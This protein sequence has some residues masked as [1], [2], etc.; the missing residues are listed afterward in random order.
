[1][2]VQLML[3]E[4]EEKKRLRTVNIDGQVW[5]NARDVCS[6]LEIVNYRD[7]V[8]R[9][10]DDEKRL[11]DSVPASPKNPWLVNESGLYNLIFSS[12]KPEAKRFRK[13]VTSEVLPSI[14]QT[15]S[16]SLPGADLGVHS[17][18]RRFNQNWK[19]VTPGFYSVISELYLRLHG[20]FEMEGHTLPDIGKDGKALCADISV[21]RTFSGWLKKNHP[22]AVNQR[23]QYEHEYPDGRTVDAYQYPHSTL[24]LFIEFVDTVWIPQKASQY[25]KKKD[26]KA[27]EYLP[28][29]LP[30]P[31][32]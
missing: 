7:A 1:M 4:Y 32:S 12:K 17:F 20:R 6:A 27:L 26:P 18:V 5:F 15:G 11:Q 16:F 22:E 2:A 9:L 23:Q 29:L 19:N 31:Q 21:G 30:P 10:D 28:K 3:F 25:L 14:R 24:P 13:W 8:S